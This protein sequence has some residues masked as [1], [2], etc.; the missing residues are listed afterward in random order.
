MP[1]VSAQDQNHNGQLDRVLRGALTSRVYDLA[2]ETPLDAAKILSQR[3]GNRVFLKREDLQPVFSFKLRGAYNRMALLTPDELGLGVVCASAGNHAQGVALSAS[4]LKCR[5]VIVM[6][7]T[8]PDIKVASVARLGG[9]VVLFGESYDEAYTHARQIEVQDGLTFVHPYDDPLVIAGQAT[10]GLE[11]LRQSQM[12][13]HGRLDAVFVAV[14]GGGLIAGVGAVLKSLDPHIKIIGVEPEDANSM[15]LSLEAGHPITLD[16]VGRFSDGVAVKRVGD[17]TFNI[18]QEVI[19]EMVVVSND[20][21]CGAIKEIFEDRRAILEPAGALAY[22]GLAAWVAKHGAMGLNLAVIACGA[23]VNFDTLRHVSERAELGENREAIL[24]VTIPE[25]PGSF[26]AFCRAIGNR[27]ITEFNYRYA[28]A[29]EAQVFVGIRTTGPD[30]SGEIVQQLTDA[31]FATADLS[32]NET[33][34]LHVRHMVGGRAPVE[35][36]RLFSFVF[37]ERVGALAKFLD[38]MEHPWNISLF[39]Y[40]NHGSDYGRVLCGI[41]VPK[42][43]EADLSAF[44]ARLGYEW[45]EETENIACTRFL[46]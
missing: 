13:G 10:I 3:V 39:H 11:L 26:R 20:A 31:G 40:R 30:S 1:E 21:I 46:Q 6:P 44:L 15:T 25:Q 17:R 45:Q 8:T 12:P 14:G 23:N 37:P 4:H 27:S 9:E 5:A 28:P 2:I 42:S 41:Q 43:E 38:A 19:D 18:A 24:A 29:A 22:A 7:V 16:R 35:N 32:R 33:A 36:E 34:K